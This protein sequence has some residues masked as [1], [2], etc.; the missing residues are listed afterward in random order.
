MKITITM[1]LIIAFLT[2]VANLQAQNYFEK[3]TTKSNIVKITFDNGVGTHFEKNSMNDHW[4]NKNSAKANVP[5]FFNSNYAA[6]GKYD[7]VVFNRTDG[8]S[9]MSYDLKNWQPIS[10]FQTKDLNTFINSL[11]DNPQVIISPNPV[12][13]KLNVFN[14]EPTLNE[15][16]QIYSSEGMLMLDSKYKEQ[17]DVSKFATGIYLLKIGNLTYKFIKI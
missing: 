1:T 15:K 12:E 4:I 11:S 3:A 17:I 14:S 8:K 16:M 6:Y 9:Y 2:I 13:D 10:K 5:N 7:R